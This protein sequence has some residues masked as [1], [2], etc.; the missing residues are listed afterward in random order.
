MKVSLAAQVMGHTVE[1]GLNSLV[2]EGKD[3]CTLC[4][5]LYAVMK[6]VANNE[7]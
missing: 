7:D 2:A 5:D 6:E 3:H 1:A 4:Y